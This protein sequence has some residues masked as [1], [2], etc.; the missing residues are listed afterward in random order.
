MI[1]TNILMAAIIKIKLKKILIHKKIIMENENQDDLSA[2]YKVVI[3]II[4]IIA[5]F[6]FVSG[7]IEF[8]DN[9]NL[10]T[11]EQRN[12]VISTI[13]LISF[14]WYTFVVNKKKK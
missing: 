2:F 9:G 11:D 1:Q 7:I 3:Y 8:I 6:F 12:L 5:L 10:Y 14:V 13:V 4:V